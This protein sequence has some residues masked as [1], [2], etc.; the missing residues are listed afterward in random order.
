MSEGTLH[1]Y[2]DIRRKVLYN[3]FPLFST[4]NL[5]GFSS[6]VLAPITFSKIIGKNNIVIANTLWFGSHL[7]VGLYLF[8]SKHLAA[9][10]S[11]FDRILYSVFGS[12]IFNFGSVL[13]MSIVRSIY[14]NEEK[15]R[16]LVGLSASATLLIIGQRWLSYIDDIFSTIRFRSNT[17]S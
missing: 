2:A 11:P 13:L 4:T 15:L 8:G 7:G 5:L 16:L 10:S 12:A 14:P 9:S 6:H 17:R 1:H 3:Y